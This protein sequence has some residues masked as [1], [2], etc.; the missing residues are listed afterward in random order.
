[1]PENGEEIIMRIW[2]LPVRQLCRNHLLG[3]HRELHAVWNIITQGKKG[4]ATHPETRRWT[5][6][7]GALFARHEQQVGE[8][9]R[10]G[11]KHESP[12]DGG[13]ATGKA[14][15]DV[16]VTPIKEQKRMLIDRGCGCFPGAGDE[17]PAERGAVEEGDRHPS[18][19]LKPRREPAS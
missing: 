3:E 11:W 14:D 19:R 7:L 6:K 17:Q 18:R 13:A 12:L 10:R 5:G 9:A 16:F 4:Y 15:Q 2:D 1:M 8:I